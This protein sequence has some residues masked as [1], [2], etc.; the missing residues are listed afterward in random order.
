MRALILIIGFI[1]VFSAGC[2][3]EKTDTISSERLTNVLDPD[4]SVQLFKV[5]SIDIVPNPSHVT[6]RFATRRDLLNPECN[7]AN[8]IVFRDSL[9]RFKLDMG[10]DSIFFDY[11]VSR[12]KSY[13][14]NFAF[15]SVNKDTTKW[16]EAYEV[17]IP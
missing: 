7:I 9:F 8:V 16:S 15:I 14:Y 2:R 3:K 11:G 6:F 10:N 1:G 4:T 13:T 5:N 17:Y 12:L